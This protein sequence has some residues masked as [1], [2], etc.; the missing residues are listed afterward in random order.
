LTRS[1]QPDSS[2]FPS[3]S[4]DPKTVALPSSKLTVIPITL[5]EANQFVE[6]FHRH[7]KRTSRDGGKFAIGASS[8][9]ALVGVAIVGLPLARLLA[10]GWTAE[11]LRCCTLNDAPKGTNSFLY[12]ASWRVWR[13]MGGKRLVTYTLKTESGASLR[14]AGW[15]VVAESIGHTW[16]R[17][18]LG[19]MREWQPIYGQMKFRWEMSA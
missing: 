19:R 4:I 3:T 6:Q 11:V 1:A 15:K 17:E 10:N 8:G 2:L 7:N 16:N 13:E 12:A 14:G 5:R 18:N 9:S